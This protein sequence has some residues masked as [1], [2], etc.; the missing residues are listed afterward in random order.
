VAVVIVCVLIVG[1]LIWVCDWIIRLVVDAL[2]NLF[3]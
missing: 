1:V 2:M 3:G